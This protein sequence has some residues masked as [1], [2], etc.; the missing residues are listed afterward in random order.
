L[1]QPTC[2]VYLAIDELI[3]SR[4]IAIDGLAGFLT[5]LDRGGI[6]CVW[7]TSRTRLQI[8]EARRKMAHTHPFIAEDGCGVYLPEDYFHLRPQGGRGQREAAR[9]LRLGRFTCIPIAESQPAAAEALESLSADTGVSVVPLRSLSPRE[10]A[11]NSGLQPREAELARQRDFDELFFFA[12]ASNH[13]VRLF[14][15]AAQERKVQLRQREAVWSLAVGASTVACI[16]AVS[17]LYDRALHAHAKIVG[18]AVSGQAQEFFAGC[19]RAV[20]LTRTA[21]AEH[22]SGKDAGARRVLKVPLNSPNKWE[23]LGD[24]LTG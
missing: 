9:T 16:R 21:E 20:L 5:T 6:P 10:L 13:Q 8:D 7:L 23:L 14:E 18:I 3:Y 1:R 2:A 17:K 24:S 15:A 12:G 22:V 19:D 4:G 11:Q